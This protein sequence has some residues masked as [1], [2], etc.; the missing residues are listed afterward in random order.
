MY[1]RPAHAEGSII[2]WCYRDRTG[3]VWVRLSRPSSYLF[4]LII[5]FQLSMI[6]AVL[7]TPTESDWPG[8]TALPA[9]AQFEARSSTP[10]AAIFPGVSPSALHLL[11]G[12]LTFDPLKRITADDALRHEYFTS[13]PFNETPLD[14]LPRLPQ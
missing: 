11:Q 8:V 4:R 2:P 12:M 3:V 9:Y 10:F 6:F 7:G 1:L 14:Q 5:F 13:A